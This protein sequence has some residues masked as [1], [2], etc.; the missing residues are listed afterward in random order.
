ME[1]HI[2]RSFIIYI[3]VMLLFFV[4]LFWFLTRSS[5]TSGQGPS[6]NTRTLAWDPQTATLVSRLRTIGLPAYATE[7]D[8]FHI[9]QH[10]DL[11]I[12][13]KQ[14]T[15]SAGIGIDGKDKLVAPV[16]THDESG[17]IHVEASEPHNFTLGQFFD[18]W[19][20]RF[21]SSCM[22][23]YC[24]TGTSTLKIYSNGS[25]VTGDPRSLILTAHE[26]IVIAYGT[27]AELPKQIPSNYNFPPGD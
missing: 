24:N 16:H 8:A 9:H 27:D 2:N 11:F 4:G 12:D 19:G 13:G 15:V 14:I 25:P 7:Q 23:E 20:V 17:I 10:L 5:N 21:T 26:E 6:P 18:I 3:F 1:D 22:G